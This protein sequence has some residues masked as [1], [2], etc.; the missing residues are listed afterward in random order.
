MPQ[1]E[2][3]G[4]QSIQDHPSA[5]NCTSQQAAP[6]DKPVR[7][8]H[9]N[10]LQGAPTKHASWYTRDPPQRASWCWRQAGQATPKDGNTRT[11]ARAHTLTLTVLQPVRAPRLS[12]AAGTHCVTIGTDS[13]HS[14]LQVWANVHKQ[15]ACLPN[16]RHVRHK[17]TQAGQLVVRQPVD[18][19]NISTGQHSAQHTPVRH[20]RLAARRPPAKHMP[21]MPAHPLLHS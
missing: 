8:Q 17:P 11:H 10:A 12:G 16:S 6:T 7:A 4:P 14:N 21:C 18:L 5:Y 20:Q 19:P 3:R 2:N 9:A 13:T 1:D 15:N